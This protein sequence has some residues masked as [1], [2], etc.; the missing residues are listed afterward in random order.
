MSKQPQAVKRS[1]GGALPYPVFAKS[2]QPKVQRR[3]TSHRQDQP[4]RARSAL[5]PDH[6]ELGPIRTGTGR[7]CVW[8]VHSLALAAPVL[9]EPL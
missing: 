7:V 1:V 2:E 6:V 3:A 8:L 4:E 9:L 5:Q